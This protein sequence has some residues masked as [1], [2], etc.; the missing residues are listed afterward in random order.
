M[1]LGFRNRENFGPE[2][3]LSGTQ[4]QN[5]GG[6]QMSP[7]LNAFLGKGCTYEG[8][9]TFEGRVRIDGVFK[10][11]I[12][13]NDTLE[14]GKDATVEGQIDVATLVVSG[15][16]TGN[17]NARTRVELHKPAKVDGTITTPILVIQEGVVFDGNVSMGSA[18]KSAAK[19]APVDKPAAPKPV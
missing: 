4:P 12:F 17:I 6:R 3:D 19:P 10:G 13:S 5:D 1:A 2:E 7:E 14:I 11:E 16:V 8:K 15:N 18:Q 9:L